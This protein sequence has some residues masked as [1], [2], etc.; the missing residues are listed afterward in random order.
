MKKITALNLLARK[1]YGSDALKLNFSCTASLHC[2]VGSHLVTTL[3]KNYLLYAK[4]YAT[5]VDCKRTTWQAA[6]SSGV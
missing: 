2:L 6:F 1:G 4:A 3:L 5:W